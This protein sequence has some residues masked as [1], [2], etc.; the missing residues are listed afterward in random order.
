MIFVP[1]GDRRVDFTG[2]RRQELMIDETSTIV[3]SVGSGSPLVFLHGGGT[4]HGLAYTEGWP[5]HFELFIPHHPGFGQ[6]ANNPRINSIQGYVDHYVE[7]LDA[8]NLERVDLVGSSLGGRMA[9]EFTAQH[10]D[11]VNKLVLVAPAGLDVPEHPQ[12]NFSKIPPESFPTYLVHDLQTIYPYL[13]TEDDEE[14]AAMRAREGY[15]AIRILHNGSMINPAMPSVLERVN[16]QTLLVWGKQDKIVP[17]GQGESWERHLK[18]AKLKVF[19]QVGH[20]PLDESADA[21]HAVLDFLL[22]D[23]KTPTEA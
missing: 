2:F 19:D 20:L 3:H 9:A 21:R 6:S 1:L 22:S 12:P 11:R 7:L 10:G 23:R 13:P 5:A 14:F 8:L 18:N 15:A 4:W 17:V 16:H